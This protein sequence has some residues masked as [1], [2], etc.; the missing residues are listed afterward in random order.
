MGLCVRG[1]HCRAGPLLCYVALAWI[2]EGWRIMDGGWSETQWA[3]WGRCYR[4]VEFVLQ[5]AGDKPRRRDGL[6]GVHVAWALVL[7]IEP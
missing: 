4:L 2:A 7:A 3:G 1:A 5:S 6:R